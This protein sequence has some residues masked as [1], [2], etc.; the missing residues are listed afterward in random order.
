MNLNILKNTSMQRI[1]LVAKRTDAGRFATIFKRV[2]AQLKKFDK[3][4]FIEKH[5]AELIGLKSY[6]VFNRGKTEVDLL[7]VMGGDGTILSVVRSMRKFE[8]PIFGINLG[9]LGFLSEIPPKAIGKE[10]AKIFRG[11]YTL[12]KR[13]MAHVEVVREK[14]VVHVFHALNEAV[15]SHGSLARLIDLRTRVDRKK[16]T[17][18]HADGL[19]IS[20]PTGSTAYSLSAGGPIVYPSLEAFILTPIAPH[21]FTQKPIVIPSKKTIEVTIDTPQKKINLTVDGQESTALQYKDTIRVH[22]NGTALFVRLPSESFF[23]TL[24]EK[25]DW[26]KKLEA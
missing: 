7:I 14:K 8:T 6:E 4:L 13:F 10:L 11:E 24:R 2:Y 16:V 23:Q 9:N 3:E 12:D 5:I 19:I 26:G 20:T 17:T 1:G 22:R 18:Y 21:S 25:L 15:I